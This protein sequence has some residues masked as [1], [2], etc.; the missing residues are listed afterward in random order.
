MEELARQL[1][2]MGLGQKRILIVVATGTCGTHAGLVAGARAQSQPFDI[3]GVSVSGSTPVKLI[4][5]A[6][7]ATETL[8]LAGYD[9][10]VEPG[11]IWIEDRYIGSGYGELTKE[12]CQAITTAAVTEGLFLDPV[13]TGKAMAALLDM[14]P[15]GQLS[16]Y[17]AV[18]F[19]HTGGL[20]LL[21]QYDSALVSFNK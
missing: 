6:K 14:G 11:E 2:P 17:D 9:H 4:K 1:H 12:C 7:V 19:L 15:S 18:V 10:L 21:F 3:L 5:T 8:Q 16:K 20:P 13:Y